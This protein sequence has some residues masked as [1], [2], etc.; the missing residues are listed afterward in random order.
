MF[1]GLDIGTRFGSGFLFSHGHPGFL[2]VHKGTPIRRR[3]K[4]SK[5]TG[6]GACARRIF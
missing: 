2:F 5:C 1:L 3:E 4:E 6:E